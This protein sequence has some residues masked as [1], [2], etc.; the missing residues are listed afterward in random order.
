M[1]R[2]TRR[3]GRRRKENRGWFKKGPDPRRSPYRLT[4]ED[5][6]KGWQTTLARYPHLGLWLF[7]RVKTT[8][9]SQE[10]KS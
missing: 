6:K 5:R 1:S 2:T 3:R 7:L 10:G 9:P 4:R 8:C